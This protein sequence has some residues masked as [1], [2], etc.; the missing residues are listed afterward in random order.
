MYHRNT[1]NATFDARE[2]PVGDVPA[3]GFAE[4]DY[5]VA[6]AKNLFRRLTGYPAADRRERDSNAKWGRKAATAADQALAYAKDLFRR[7]RVHPASDRLDHGHR[8]APFGHGTRTE[9]NHAIAY[10]KDLFRR[11][12]GFPGRAGFLV[13]KP[14]SVANA[15]ARAMARLAR[16]IRA[17]VWEPYTRI[18]RR[19]IA[20]AQLQALDD[21][22]LADIGLAR[23]DI[24]PTVDGML[25][26]R[27]Q[28]VARPVK[29]LPPAGES[30]HE[31]PLAA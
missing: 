5:A 31:L 23:A 1:N 6:H 20:I 12:T 13:K 16:P 4:A 10:A 25:R 19:K 2:G 9:A 18:R 11:L 21:R 7:L 30:R 8:G 15:T 14:V 29:R 26:R 17:T 28:P 3:T 24:V 27:D 22:L